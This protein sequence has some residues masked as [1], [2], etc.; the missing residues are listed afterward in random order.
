MDNTGIPL[1][2]GISV[3]LGFIVGAAIAGQTFYNFIQENLK[4]YAA[5]KA[6]GL[7]NAVLARMVMLQAMVVGLIG[8]GNGVGLTAIFGMQVHDTVL[9]F[10]CCIVGCSW[11][12]KRED[13][14]CLYCISGIIYACGSMS[15]D[16][17]V[18]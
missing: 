12:Q 6:M 2:F 1:N 17:Q 10:Y 18:L 16:H 14:R 7:K 4:Y 9:A 3:L 11:R 13:G 15:S 8:Y 5:L